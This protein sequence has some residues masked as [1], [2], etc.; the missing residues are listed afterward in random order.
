[1]TMVA[2]S[3]AMRIRVLSGRSA[4]RRLMLASSPFVAKMRP[5]GAL[6]AA[7]WSASDRCS[8]RARPASFDTMLVSLRTATRIAHRAA[9]ASAPC[10]RSVCAYGP[11][12]AARSTSLPRMPASLSSRSSGGGAASFFSNW[13][14]RAAL[15]PTMPA[16][17]L[18]R[19]A[20]RKRRRACGSGWLNK[21]LRK[22]RNLMWIESSRSRVDPE[23]SFHCGHSP[24]QQDPTQH[25]GVRRAHMGDRPNRG[26]D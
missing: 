21:I 25:M 1:M 26:T 2:A 16:S 13:E 12:P 3:T 14:M 22:S 7:A 8:A 17:S 15:T 19:I 10:H 4:V 5:S 11:Q 9:L 20:P 23:S 6:A 24:G 18:W